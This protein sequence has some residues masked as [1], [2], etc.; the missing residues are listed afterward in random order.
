MPASNPAPTDPIKPI[1]PP[2]RLI[3]PL[4]AL[5]ELALAT[6]D[7]LPVVVALVP[8]EVAVLDALP[9]VIS[10]RTEEASEANDPVN[11]AVMEDAIDAMREV[12]ER[13]ALGIEG[14]E[15]PEGMVIVNLEKL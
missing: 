7:P 3:A 8:V 5:V 14:I 2:S 10:L 15:I 11:V 1:N 12:S 6:L 4:E 13:T 9:P